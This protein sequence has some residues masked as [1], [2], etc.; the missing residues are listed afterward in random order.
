VADITVERTGL[1]VRTVMEIL[2]AKP[3]GVKA[4]DALDE[5][6]MRVPL[7]EFELGTYLDGQPRWPKIV[8]FAT[9]DL[10][11]AGWLTKQRGYWFITEAGVAA[12]IKYQD[13][14][15]FYREAKTLYAAWRKEN[16]KDEVI[17][18]E[19]QPDPEDIEESDL[20]AK[21]EEAEAD[22]WDQVTKHLSIMDPFRFQDLIAGLLIGM[23]YHVSWISPPGPDR[24]LD[25]VAYTD[26]LGANGPRIKVQVKR[27]ADKASA[28]S[29]RSFIALLGDHDVGLFVC[30]GGFTNS[31]LEEV[32]SQHS[33]RITL[34][35]A[36][37]LF[38]L[39]VSCYDKIPDANR[40]LMPMRPVHFLDHRALN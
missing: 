8:R 7:T 6:A 3:A 12:L 36:S 33:R 19:S 1:L 34:M 9:I 13:P 17:L 14:A 32:R 4:K 11:K 28:E 31:A 2:Q 39:W 24:G 29:V 18:D 35:D 15:A 38:A 25:I 5:M 26:P 30:T 40:A 10:V 16:P 27:R 37:Q 23:G 20:G 22:A 21:L